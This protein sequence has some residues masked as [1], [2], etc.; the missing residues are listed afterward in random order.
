MDPYFKVIMMATGYFILTISAI[1]L[2]TFLV[3]VVKLEFSWFFGLNIFESIK[4]FSIKV[5]EKFV[6]IL[7]FIRGGIDKANNKGKL[8]VETKI[9]KKDIRLNENKY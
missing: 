2:L 9:I 4:N 5:K 6:K 8:N 7:V 1:I 3:W